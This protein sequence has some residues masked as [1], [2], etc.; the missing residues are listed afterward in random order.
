MLPRAVR[1]P[2]AA[3]SK[4]VHGRRLPRRIVRRSAPEAAQEVVDSDR[5]AMGS[6]TPR[7][8][9][10][11]A[12]TPRQVGIGP[13]PSTRVR[14]AARDAQAKPAKLALNSRCQEVEDRLELKQS[15]EQI[16]NRLPL[17][18]PDD[19]EMRVF[20]ET[21]STSIYVQGRG[22]LRKDL[23]GHLRTGR[24]MRKPRAQRRQPLD[25]G[26]AY[27]VRDVVSISERP[28]WWR[29]GRYPGTGRGS[30]YWAPPRLGDRHPGQRATGF[31]GLLH[32]PGDHTALT[33]QTA[34]WETWPPC[35]RYCADLDLG[36][37]R[38]DDRPREDRRGHRLGHLLLRSRITVAARQ[39]R[40]HQRAAA[41]VPPQGH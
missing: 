32:L 5:R 26:G 20:H 22:A 1:E 35:P 14:Q 18:F 29:T 2:L 13:P 15:P 9:R 21:M 4:A 19:P 38:R 41:P 37:R 33:M 17:D 11:L 24:A 7:S 8:A 30:D 3:S 6:R 27:P 10:E 16:A 25:S 31:V 23:A 28:P 36:P 39:Q 34:I 12:R 40:E